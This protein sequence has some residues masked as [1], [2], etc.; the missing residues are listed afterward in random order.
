VEL[1]GGA[2]EGGVGSDEAEAFGVDEAEAGGLDDLL[3]RGDG[4]GPVADHRRHVHLRE[5]R[6]RVGREREGS[7]ASGGIYS[8]PGF[9]P[10]RATH[11]WPRM[12]PS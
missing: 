7:V 5:A 4:L 11:I 9:G 12:G 10:Y 3:D 2:D 6:E 1:H 8:S